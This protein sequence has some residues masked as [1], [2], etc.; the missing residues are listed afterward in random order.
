MKTLTTREFFHSPSLVKAL[1]PGQ[2][3][4]VT[5]QGKPSIVVTRSGKRPRRS[6]EAM[7]Q[8]A[9]RIVKRMG[10][11]MDFTRMRREMEGR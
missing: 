4:L 2:S 1:N 5:D 7:E 6:I 11:K 8:E 9:R 3:L 10:P